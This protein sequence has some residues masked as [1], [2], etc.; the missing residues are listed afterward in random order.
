M[1]FAAPVFERPELTPMPV[2]LSFPQLVAKL[3]FN[4]HRLHLLEGLRRASIE[5]RRSGCAA[6]YV[7]GS[8]TGSKEFPSDYDAC[9]NPIGVAA[10][11]SPLLVEE[12]YLSQRRSEYLGDW[13]IGRPD[14]GPPGYWYRFLAFDDRTGLPNTMFGVKLE[15][16][17]LTS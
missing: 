6:V 15:L 2:W 12:R 5:L 16:A 14:E 1:N 8:F 3:G 13:L 17:E 11:L 4:D 10:S 7:G 9:F